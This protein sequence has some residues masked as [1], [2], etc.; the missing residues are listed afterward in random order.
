MEALLRHIPR[1][2]ALQ[3]PDEGRALGRDEDEAALRKFSFVLR[4]S[5]R[6]HLVV[7]DVVKDGVDLVRVGDAD[8]HRMAVEM[9]IE[10]EG[11]LEVL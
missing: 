8:G 7:H 5:G 2:H 9:R 10:E 6:T 11:V 3:H 1:Y 4:A